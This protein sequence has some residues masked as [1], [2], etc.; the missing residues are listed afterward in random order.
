MN[1]KTE[2]ETPIRVGD[3]DG[4][5]VIYS[6]T[7]ALVVSPRENILKERSGCDA[8]VTASWRSILAKTFFSS[9]PGT[10]SGHLY[11]TTHRVVLIRKLDLWKE[12]KPLLTPLSLPAA[13]GKENRAKE[14]ISRGGRQYCEIPTSRFTIS[15]ARRK[16]TLA[17]LYLKDS[18]GAK[19]RVVLYTDEP[20]PDFLLFVQNRFGLK[21]DNSDL[22]SASS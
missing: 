5:G 2:F 18:N 9:A 8:H 14:I 13:A 4:L 11:I 6:E 22:R 3:L 16:D 19:Y 17:I 20:D 15:A 12:I 21:S 7:G 10:P 1:T